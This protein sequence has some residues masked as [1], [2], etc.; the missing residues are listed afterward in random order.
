VILTA[1]V[2]L[3]AQQQRQTAAAYEQLKR[4]SQEKEEQ[5]GR[6]ED[7]VQ[8]LA[9]DLEKHR[10]HIQ[11]LLRARRL[12]PQ[13]EDWLR[14][15]LELHDKLVRV[16]SSQPRLRKQIAEACRWLGYIEIKLGQ[17]DQAEEFY[18]SVSRL[19]E[20]GKTRF[21]DEPDYP[22]DL[23]RIHNDLGALL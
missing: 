2:V 14:S 16:N 6:A 11:E 7:A 15:R 12:D 18:R 1:S 21:P 23:A 22:R 17:L 4:A 19:L 13:D 8:A 3:I 20:A 10:P 5:Q 9:N